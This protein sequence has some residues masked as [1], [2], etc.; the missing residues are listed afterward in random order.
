MTTKQK[1]SIATALTACLLLLLMLVVSGYSYRPPDP[2]LPEEGVEISLGDSENGAGKN[3]ESNVATNNYAPPAAQERVVTQDATKTVPVQSSE[4]TG[5]RTNPEASTQNEP[6]N[7]EPELNPNATYRGRSRNTTAHGSSGE[8]S[9]SGQ[10]VQG[11]SNGA[12]H[13]S[14]DGGNYTLKGRSAVKLQQPSRKTSKVGTVV[15][16]ITVNWEGKVVKAEYEP[17]NSNSAD[18]ELMDM[19]IEAAKKSKFNALPTQA[20]EQV[21]YITYKFVNQ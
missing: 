8:G 9:T 19:A 10:N 18:R 11:S 12:G 20:E 16:K 7:K 21:G 4:N 3:A 1:A 6:Q 2:P 17:T 14:G 13:S 15:V 5:D